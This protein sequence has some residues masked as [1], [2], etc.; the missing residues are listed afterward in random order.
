MVV[1][2]HSAKSFEIVAEESWDRREADYPSFGG[3]K[4]RPRYQFLEHRWLADG[5]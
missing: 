3:F 2:Q 1:A 5:G 4:A